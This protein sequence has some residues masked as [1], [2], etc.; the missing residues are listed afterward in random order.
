[1]AEGMKAK[2]KKQISKGKSSGTAFQKNQK[3]S[4]DHL[5]FAF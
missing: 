2:V 4:T 5:I 1:M 3:E